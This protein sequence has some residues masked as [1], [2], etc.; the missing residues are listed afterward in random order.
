[1][2]GS[3]AYGQGTPHVYLFHQFATRK[4][5]L[6]NGEF[7]S[8]PMLCLIYLGYYIYLHVVVSS[9]A[10]T[11]IEQNKEVECSLKEILID[12]VVLFQEHA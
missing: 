11:S 6:V 8:T 9:L 7:G 12:L 3:T 4:S 1:V 2:H 5:I 10:M